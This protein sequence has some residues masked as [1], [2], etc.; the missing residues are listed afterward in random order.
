MA[1]PLRRAY[2]VLFAGVALAA[3]AFGLAATRVPP[4][5]TSDGEFEGTWYREEPGQK[6]M[7]QLRR[8]AG[9]QRWE[10]RFV[11]ETHEKFFAD[12]G[13]QTHHEFAFKGLPGTFDLELDPASNNNRV[14]LH[15]SRTQAGGHD[16]KLVES[17]D[18]QIYRTTDGHSLAWVQA[19][20]TVVNVGE[21]IAPYQ[22]DGA[23][24]DEQ[25]VWIFMKA[26]RRMLQ[27]DE[28][29]W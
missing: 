9:S 6:Q 29:P 28:V 25:R 10:L 24:K 17:G 4:P 14:L 19:L 11:W 12:T 21:P 27:W 2:C 1:Q 15:Y 20:H 26:S 16:S 18:T 3:V 23:V 7:L 8:A 13:W 22:E 5:P